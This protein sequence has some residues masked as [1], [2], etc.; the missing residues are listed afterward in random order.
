MK[1]DRRVALPAVTLALL[2]GSCALPP[3]LETSVPPPVVAPGSS[4]R[5]SPVAPSGPLVLHGEPRIDI[6]LTWSAD[7]IVL[8][9]DG[10]ELSAVAMGSRARE[11]IGDV[12]RY[13][14]M[15][16]R[17]HGTGTRGDT[18]EVMASGADRP[19]TPGTLWNGRH[20]R[21]VLRVFVNPRGTLTLAARLPLE[22]YLLGVVPGEIGALSE[23]LI[24]AGR[25]QAIAAR[26]YTVYYL[27]RRVAEGFDLYGSTEDQVYGAVESERPLAT[28]VVQS[29]RGMLAL[30][31]GRAIRANYCSTCGGMT[32]DVWE[33][34]PADPL[35][36]L[37]SHRDAGRN[38]TDFCAASPQ[39]RW[40]EEWSPEEFAANIARF[41]SGQGVALPAGGVGD[42]LDVR[43]ISRSTSGRVWRLAVTTTTGEISVPAWSLRQVLRRGGN[44]AAILR[45]NLFK[46][47]VRRD[48]SNGRARAIV[49]SG[50]GSGHGVGLCQT[51]ALGM[52]RAGSSSSEIL[53]HY[54]RGVALERLY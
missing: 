9:G 2:A 52:A 20:W 19:G 8:G 37:V 21:G 54:Y 25:A 22:D 40:R 44:P 4:P 48:R 15:N 14:V 49:A 47:D 16:G 23:D 1:L 31:N 30:S 35:S 34:W 13:T 50:A 18:I 41:G 28:K 7:T 27:G 46:I 29:T 10:L 45:S 11:P 5:P 33:A 39:F 43:C 3:R 53:L 42:V 51:G 12:A 38:G 26:S 24:E 32:A 36:Y 6:G 17:L